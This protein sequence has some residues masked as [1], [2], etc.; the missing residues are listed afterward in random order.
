M[1][2]FFLFFILLQQPGLDNVAPLNP[3]EIQA[4]FETSLGEFVIQFHPELAPKHVENFLQLAQDDFY[5]G[6]T[7]HSMVPH[8]IVQAG[9][10]LTK[11]PD[12]SELYGSGGF[13]MGI[14]QEISDLEFTSGTVVAT[15]LPGD[16]E[17][18]GSQF[19]ICVGD[20]PQFTGMFTAF[21]EVVE[22]LE[23][24]D[25]ISMRPTDDKQIAVERIEILTMTIRPIPPP[26]IPLFSEET[27]DTLANH[28]IVMETSKGNIVLEFFPEK[29]PNHVRHFLRL[30]ALGVYDKTAFH[31]VAPGFVVQ[32]GDLNT[33]SE[34]YPQ[35]AQEF[36]VPITAEINEI[37]HTEGIVS[38]ARGEEIDSALTSFFIVLGDQPPLDNFYTVFGRVTDG[39]EVVRD[40]EL[41][42]TFGERPL[43]RIDIYRMRV[44][45]KN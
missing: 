12:Q 14:E 40:I 45:P 22:G 9:D 32:A 37:K 41:V 16:T 2:A 4:V 39:M 29:A 44:E 28:R 13:N 7:F 38:M 15:Q 5:I 20:Q 30:T 18:A 1:T 34:P 24:I 33:R 43:E 42:E 23:I 31:R 35:T 17:S 36:V 27:I 3:K 6:T 10:P 26:P 8:G 25:Q 21:G 19:F 11:D